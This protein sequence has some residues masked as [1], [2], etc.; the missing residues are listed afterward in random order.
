MRLIVGDLVL[1]CDGVPVDAAI[2]HDSWKE[3]DILLIVQ[4]FESWEMNAARRDG[5]NLKSRE[6]LVLEREWGSVQQYGVV[7]TLET[8]RIYGVELLP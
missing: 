2:G 1:V 4:K 3:C 7:L 6:Y 5:S 8:D